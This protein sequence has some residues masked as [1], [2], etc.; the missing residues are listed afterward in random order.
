MTGD[1]KKRILDGFAASYMELARYLTRRF[2]AQVETDDVLQDTYLRLQ[3]VRVDTEIANARSYLF[4]AA[5]NQ[6]TDHIRARRAFERRFHL[7]DDF[8]GPDD[9]PS[10]EVVTDYRQRLQILEKAVGNLPARQKQVFLM[11]KIDGLSHGQIAAELGITK[12]AVEKLVMR[13]LAHL[14]DQLD[15]II[16]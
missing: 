11:H 10:P 4:R 14:R 5:R 9:T 13:A 2:G 1:A 12:S 6:A 15:D 16:E 3:N 8:E 7:S